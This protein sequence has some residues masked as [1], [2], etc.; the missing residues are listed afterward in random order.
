MLIFAVI[1]TLWSV[2]AS[3]QPD[4]LVLVDVA[5]STADD[6]FVV[7]DGV[8]GGVFSSSMEVTS[9]GTGVF[10]G[11]LSLENNGGFASVRT[12]PA[13]GDLSAFASIPASAAMVRTSSQQP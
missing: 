7:S 12:A 2:P 9:G 5:R 11:R 1:M 3:Q 8:M 13:S 10:A 4:S 6:W